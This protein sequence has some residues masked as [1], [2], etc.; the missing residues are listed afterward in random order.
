[1]NMCMWHRENHPSDTCRQ[2]GI[3]LL[4]YRLI[5]VGSERDANQTA[6]HLHRRVGDT[7]CAHLSIYTL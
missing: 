5:R 7:L 2:T 3:D 6:A 4:I 1:M